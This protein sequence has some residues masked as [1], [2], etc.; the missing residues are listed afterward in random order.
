MV[1][2]IDEVVDGETDVSVVG[3]PLEEGLAETVAPT[4][5]LPEPLPCV[6]PVQPAMR[7]ADKTRSNAIIF[8]MSVNTR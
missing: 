4:T 5:T 1:E 3:T 8:F 2:G 7:S 6:P